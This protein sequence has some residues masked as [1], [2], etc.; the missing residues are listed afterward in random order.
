MPHAF[1]AKTWGT[2]NPKNPTS[3]WW[4]DR[5]PKWSLPFTPQS[6]CPIKCNTLFKSTPSMEAYNYY[7][8]F[9]YTY[10]YKIKTYVLKKL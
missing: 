8:I 7:I 2:N 10:S 6:R 5:L 1:E 3:F 9:I 4:V